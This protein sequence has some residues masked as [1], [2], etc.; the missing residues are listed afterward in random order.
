[1]SSIAVA[2]TVAGSNNWGGMSVARV[3][4]WS[5]VSGR[6]SQRSGD[7]TT[8][9]T[10]E[11]DGTGAGERFSVGG[12]VVALGG[13][14]FW[15]LEW[16]TVDGGWVGQSGWVGSWLG[17]VAVS[18]AVS[19]WGSGVGGSDDWGG[20]S[21][22]WSGMSNNWGGM[23]IDGVVSVAGMSFS[24]VGEVGGAGVLDLGGIN[25]D[26]ICADHGQ[27]LGAIDDWGYWGDEAS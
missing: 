16:H 25:W 20:G 13:D 26:T 10:V 21:D 6:V 14:D 5:S 18:I 27:V 23:G 4:V 24:L 12:E 11:M 9:T 19:D 7:H 15:G 3:G 22:D 17:D 1:M 8:T 2:M